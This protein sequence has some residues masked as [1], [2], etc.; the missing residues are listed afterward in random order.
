MNVR[1][2]KALN[3]YYPYDTATYEDMRDMAYSLS[4]RT[5]DGDTI[6]NLHRELLQ[7]MLA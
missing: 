6:N 7:Y 2:I 3:Q 4:K 1:A 5:L